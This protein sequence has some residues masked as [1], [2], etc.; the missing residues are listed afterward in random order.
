MSEAGRCVFCQR[1]VS[2]ETDYRQVTGWERVIRGV[3]GT[4][5][6][7]VPDRSAERYACRFCVDKLAS[8]VAIEQQILAL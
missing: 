5:A 4:N 6:I 2:V 3:G 8:G 1:L 7:R